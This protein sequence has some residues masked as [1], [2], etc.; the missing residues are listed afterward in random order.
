M[1]LTHLDNNG[2][3][4]M[5]DVSNKEETRRIAIATGIITM[6]KEAFLTIKDNTSKKGDVLSTARIAGIM[7]SKQTSSLI[8]LCHP[9]SITKTKVNF[10]FDDV[11]YSIKAITET[12]CTGKTGVEMEALCACSISLLTIYDM[13]KAIDRS[14]IIKDIKLEEKMGG[15]SGHFKRS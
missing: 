14:M 13:V 15:K 4:I 6:S 3:A 5:V 7:G 9:I 8:P 10:E 12:A 1:Q 2:Q 11:N